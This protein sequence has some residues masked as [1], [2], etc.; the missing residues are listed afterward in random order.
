MDN[1]EALV[2]PVYSPIIK[3]KIVTY[4]IGQGVPGVK[5]GQAPEIALQ[6][7]VTLQGVK[8]IYDA[9]IQK[10]LMVD[11]T[12]STVNPIGNSVL[13]WNDSDHR[14]WYTESILVEMWFPGLEDRMD[15]LSDAPKSTEVSGSS[16]VSNSLDV[17]SG[18]F[19]GIPLANVG[20]GFSHSIS[21]NLS[22]FEVTNLSTKR[23]PVR[24]KHEYRL[25]LVEGAAYKE[26]ADLR[27]TV[28]AN[29]GG[30]FQ[31]KGFMHL[32]DLPP[33][34]KSSFPIISQ[35]LFRGDSSRSLPD[36]A[37]LHICVTCTLVDTKMA[38][39]FGP[40]GYAKKETIRHEMTAPIPFGHIQ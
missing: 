24:V 26:P 18:M 30:W 4:Y 9:P 28:G 17:S 22:D 1:T 38:Q 35:A 27:A 12:D 5:T 31:N 11:L 15:L 10:Y 19:G 13:M 32:Y 37:D 3:E 6:P 7:K 20:A 33:R 36:T 21:M 8:A 2:S 34:A 40:A 29:I 39:V 23:R 14:G 16:S 25:A